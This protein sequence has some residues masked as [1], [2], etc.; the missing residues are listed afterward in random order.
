MRIPRSVTVTTSSR[1]SLEGLSALHESATK[2]RHRSLNL[3]CA[4]ALR[5]FLVDTCRD[6][7]LEGG[8]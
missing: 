6:A 7:T 1:S 3:T 2:P 8:G 4:F 5:M